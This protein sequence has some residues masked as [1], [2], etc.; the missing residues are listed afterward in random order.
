[1]RIAAGLLLVATTA[2]GAGP[3]KAATVAPK[4][5]GGPV[6]H[7]P[8]AC[9]VKILPL[10]VGNSW[11]YESV[12]APQAAIEAIAKIA[13]LEPKFFTI[14]VVS[15]DAPKAPSIDTLVHLEE[16]VTY[17]ISRDTA[18]PKL[19]ERTVN[20]TVTCNAKGKFE[21]SPDSYFFAGEPGGYYGMT[22]DKVERPRDTTYKLVNG[23]IGQDEWREDLVAHFSRSP[24]AGVEAKLGSGKLEL[25]RK[26]TPAQPEAVST[27]MGG[28]NAEKLGLITTGR[29]TLDGTAP[30]A[31]PMELPAG[32]QSVLWLASGVGMVQS[33][34]AYAHEYQL[35]EAT[36]K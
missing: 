26:F 15:I 6:S 14:T 4:A 35:A 18:K 5:A 19:E 22:I 17:D 16:K 27:K 32:W 29:V 31:K 11:K 10:V 24:T 13:P 8:P 7:S 34:N 28:Y 33:L 30:D 25:E 23:T 1:M 12:V 3:K 2:Y 21:V 36:L 20:T 9:G